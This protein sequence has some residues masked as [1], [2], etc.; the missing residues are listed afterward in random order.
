MQMQNDNQAPQNLTRLL[1][2]Q[3]LTPFNT[4]FLLEHLA[5]KPQRIRLPSL[6]LVNCN[7]NPTQAPSPS[8]HS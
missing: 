4:G 7:P 8:F 3:S 2:P 5:Q 1:A 6:I